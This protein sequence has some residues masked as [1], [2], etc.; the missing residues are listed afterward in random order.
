M[1]FD[2]DFVG[3]GGLAY[4][5]VLRIESLPIADEKYPARLIGKLP[6][7]FIAN[8]TCAAGRLGLKTGYIGWVGDDS[9]GA[10]LR[11][12][13]EAWNVKAAGLVRVP[14]VVTPFTVVITDVKG[15]RAILLP[16]S[17]LYNMNFT[18]EQL[19]VASQAHV[20]LTFPRD[21]AWFGQLRRATRESG[22][23]IALDIENVVPMQG[24]ELRQVIRLTDIV[25]LKRSSLM[26][27][28][29]WSLRELVSPGQWLIQTSGHVGAY[30]IEHGM[31]E[32]IY[33]A[34]RS[35]EVV[36]S[37][38]AGDCFHAALIA[39][40]LGGATLREGLAFAN[41]AASIK[42]QQFGARGGLPT[43]AEV[44]TLLK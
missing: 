5:M 30:G 33:E 31:D 40:R 4:D 43:R 2:Y 6:G 22:G 15:R 44:E 14:G 3:V 41:A 25:F 28:G 9:E 27:I 13:F 23:L 19:A 8:A 17:P 11:D 1:V 12:D 26:K 34:A 20:V 16:G 42:V 29:S 36:D 18:A 21:L 10:M 35:V 37:T 24:E 39:A 38:G 7:G 32:P